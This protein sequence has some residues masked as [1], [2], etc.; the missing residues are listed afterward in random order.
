M[1][2]SCVPTFVLIFVSTIFLT[3]KEL[4]ADKVEGLFAEHDYIVKPWD[5]RI[6]CEAAHENELRLAVPSCHGDNRRNTH[7]NWTK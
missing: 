7:P 6:S 3:A 2:L 4:E 5:Q 1:V